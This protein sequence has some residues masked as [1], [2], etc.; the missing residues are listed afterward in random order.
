M[1]LP[2]WRFQISMMPVRYQVS[3]RGMEVEQKKDVQ[4]LGFFEERKE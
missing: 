4:E 2:G 3:Q 1:N